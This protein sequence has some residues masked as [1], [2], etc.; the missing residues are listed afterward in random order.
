MKNGMSRITNV[1]SRHTFLQPSKGG[2]GWEVV[3]LGRKNLPFLTIMVR[4]ASKQ[5]TQNVG[6]ASVVS[7]VIPEF[8]AGMPDAT[9]S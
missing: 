7:V 5:L 3:D 9:L 4:G 1:T 2:K 6:R 8:G